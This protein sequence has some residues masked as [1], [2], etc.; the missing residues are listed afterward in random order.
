MFTPAISA[1]S[2]S[3][4]LVITV[5]AFSTQVPVPPLLS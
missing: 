2:T 5:N 3:V 4:P 1:S